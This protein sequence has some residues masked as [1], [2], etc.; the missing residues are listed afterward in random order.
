MEVETEGLRT[1]TE[2]SWV[3]IADPSPAV[4][5]FSALVEP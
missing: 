1:T 4:T 5:V 3:L 2:Y